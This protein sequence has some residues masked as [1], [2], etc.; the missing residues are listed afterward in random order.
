VADSSQRLPLSGIRVVDFCWLIAGPLATRTLAHFGAE[1]I[2][3]ESQVR[4]DL[5]R[6][7]G[8]RPDSNTSLNIA[9]VFNDANTSKLSISLDMRTPQAREIVTRLIASSD[10]VTNNFSGEAMDR[11]GLGYADLVKIKPDI[12]MLSMPV[13][14]TTGP[15][16][17]YGGYGSHINAGAGLSAITGFAGRPPVGSGSLYPD[18]SSNPYHAVLALLAA[19]RYRR[20]TGKGQFIDLAQYEST[21][22]LLGSSVLQFTMRG[23]VPGQPGNRS[24]IAAPHGVYRCA[25]IDRWCAIAVFR[26]A[27]WAGLRTAIGDPAWCADQRFQDLDGR[28]ANED[29]LDRLLEAWTS[30]LPAYEVMHRLQRHGVPAG[31]VQNIQD[32]LEND[33][34]YRDRHVRFVE[35]PDVGTMTLHGEVIQISGIEPR[36]ERS[37][38]LMEH[39]EQVLSGMLGMSREEIDELYANDVLR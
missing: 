32:L 27:D 19:L 36:V 4:V 8:P 5:I 26:D 34:S 28:K 16:R 21:A 3:I 14:G 17:D 7:G 10:I 37:P 2:K 6:N 24:P 35:Q 1:V 18:F 31:V 20:L 25:G 38:M 23:E 30:E 22:A 33:T 39:N 11:W 12:I 9:G 15:H 13:M 29:D